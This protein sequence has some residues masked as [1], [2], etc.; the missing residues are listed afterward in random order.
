MVAAALIVG[1]LARGAALQ[2]PEA[3]WR[4]LIRRRG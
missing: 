2:A 1:V 4:D 3:V